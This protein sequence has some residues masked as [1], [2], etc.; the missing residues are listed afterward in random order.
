M[1]LWLKLCHVVPAVSTSPPG[2]NQV[3]DSPPAA[4]LHPKIDH[5]SGVHGWILVLRSL[6]CITFWCGPAWNRPRFQKMTRREG[7]SKS[8]CLCAM[9]GFAPKV[10]WTWIWV[11]H[12]KIDHSSCAHGWILCWQVSFAQLFDADP[13]G[14]TPGSSKFVFDEF[15]LRQGP[16]WRP[17]FS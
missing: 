4:S 14:T 3:D 6:F 2:G 17:D 11:W 13:P 16:A 8:N 1:D 7:T 9:G 5:S 10:G 12:P 15:W